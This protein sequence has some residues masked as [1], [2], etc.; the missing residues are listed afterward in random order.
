MIPADSRISSCG[1]LE[2]KPGLGYTRFPLQASTDGNAIVYEATPLSPSGGAAVENE[3]IARR[4]PD[5]WQ[6]V[7]LTPSRLTSRGGAGGK[8]YKAFDPG[9]GRG[10]MQ[11]GLPSLTT[12]APIEYPNFYLQPTG[13]PSTLGSLLI[14]EPP[15]RLPGEGAGSLDLAYAG[16]SADLTRVF[17]K[18]NDALTEATPFAPEAAGGALGEANLYE[19]ENGQLRLVNVGPGNAET[20]PGATFGSTAALTDAISADGSHVFWTTAAGQLYVRIAAQE[21][22]KVE[23]PGAFV[24]GSANGSKA[25]L[26]DGC[27][28]DIEIGGCEVLTTGQGGLDLGGFK[29]LLGHSKDLSRLYFVTGPTEGTGDLTS[30]STTVGDVHTS[31]SFRIGQTIEGEGIPAGTIVIAVG[32]G[33]LQFSG[34]P[35]KTTADAKLAAQG[36]LAGGEPN[37]AGATATVRGLNLYSWSNGSSSFVATLEPKDTANWQAAE[38]S[39][40]GNWFV[41]LSRVPLTGYDSTGPCES[42]LGETFQVP[43]PEA[44][45]YNSASGSLQCASCNPTGTS[46]LG[47][48]VL[49]ELESATPAN[50]PSYQPR[51][52]IDSG[53]LYFDTQDSLTP[54]DTNAGAEDVYQFE[55]NGV[56]TCVSEGGCVS[57]IS[58]GREAGDSNFIAMDP[59]GNNVFFTTRDRL[60]PTDKD[61]LI[62]L[63]DARVGGGIASEAVSPPR[64]CLGEACQPA[65]PA[66]TESQPNSSSPTE[67]NV[68]STKC[69]KG[70]VKR[71]GHC[72]KKGKHKK[73]KHKKHKQHKHKA[74][75]QK[76]KQGGSK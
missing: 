66:G 22:R 55:P 64:P 13:A 49:R 58:A 16:A 2:C 29:G 42:K 5:G 57:L 71:H 17:F 56:G 62:D 34:A 63:Y 28:Y 10:L 12:A 36:L 68:K 8:G 1:R 69:K 7:N 4:T 39:P 24:V 21:T 65:Q 3:Y 35:T 38:A 14:N 47:G 37:S 6:N 43:C 23:D 15:N 46:P 41:F 40:S 51:F 52:L 73:G 74:H 9:L 18:A 60:V 67:G 50:S 31:G 59:S 11:Q 75:G 30:G 70:K 32:S 33:T 25:L 45:I 76:S 44:F 61:E 20:F 19:W 48:T 72:V 53:R 27:L 54:A 26:N